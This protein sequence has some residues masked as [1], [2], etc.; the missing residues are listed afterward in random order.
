MSSH[1]QQVTELVHVVGTAM[2]APEATHGGAPATQAAAVSGAEAAQPAVQGGSM[3]TATAMQPATWQ[4]WLRGR[5]ASLSAS[6]W[7]WRSHVA[8]CRYHRSRL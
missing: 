1:P 7:A 5:P 4:R 8:G 2:A 3:A 6:S